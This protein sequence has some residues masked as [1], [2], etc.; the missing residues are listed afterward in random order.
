[1]TGVSTMTS[2]MLDIREIAPD[3]FTL[4]WPMFQ[5]AVTG[6]DVFVQT[7]DTTFAEAQRLWTA[8]PARAFVGE[9][10]GVVVGSYML[11]PNQPGRGDHVANAGYVV[12]EKARNQG[13]ARALCEHSL[14]IAA[15]AGFVAMQFNFV[16]ATNESAVHLWTSCGFETVGRLPGAFRHAR[17]GPVDVLIMYRRL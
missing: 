4:V 9:R 2:S 17:L 6:G 15:E 12:S 1:M 13:V 7:P 14:A 8:A 10:D 5:A 16:V 3:E 11:R